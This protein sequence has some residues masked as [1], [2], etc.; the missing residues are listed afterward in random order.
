MIADTKINYVPVTDVTFLEWETKFRAEMKQKKL[1]KEAADP[2]AIIKQREE[3]AVRMTGK[4]FFQQRIAQNIQ[5]DEIDDEGEGDF[6][7]LLDNR[8]EVGAFD[9]DLFND[10]DDVELDD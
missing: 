1:D 3:M 4:Q 9:E 10:D 2:P 7:D 8:Q 5:E 6:N